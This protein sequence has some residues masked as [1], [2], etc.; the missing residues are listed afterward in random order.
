MNGCNVAWGPLVAFLGVVVACVAAYIGWGQH[1]M[2]R[3]KVRLELFNARYELFEMLWSYLSA[4]VN[5]VEKIHAQHADLQNAQHKF[6]FLFDQAT[7]EY[8]AE[9]C[10]RGAQHQMNK[11]LV[12]QP[13]DGETLEKASAAINDGYSWFF[14]QA[15][16]VGRRLESFLRLDEWS[17]IPAWAKPMLNAAPASLNIPSSENLGAAKGKGKS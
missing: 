10:K 5:D 13:R 12:Q 1:E 9:V 6:Y 15:N 7:G 8:V 11:L 2:A 4:V 3:T 17:G 16:G 14:E